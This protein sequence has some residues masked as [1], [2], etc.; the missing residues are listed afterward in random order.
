MYIEKYWGNYIGGTDDSLTLLEYLSG[1]QK[2]EI[3]L[4]EIFAL[5][6]RKKKRMP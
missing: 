4:S 5:L 2:N 3:A 1:K 6:L